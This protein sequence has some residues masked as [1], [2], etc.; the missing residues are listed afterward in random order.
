MADCR[1]NRALHPRAP[2][3]RCSRDAA[4]MGTCRTLLPKERRVCDARRQE[5]EAGNGI[6]KKDFGAAK[7]AHKSPAKQRFLSLPRP[8]RASTAPPRGSLAE[9][10]KQHPPR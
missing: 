2:L 10:V 1:R 8:S 7:G 9:A 5:E 3:P 6:E 4:F